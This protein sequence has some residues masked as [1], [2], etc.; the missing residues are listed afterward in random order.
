MNSRFFLKNGE[1]WA[2]EFPELDVPNDTIDSLEH[3]LQ[4]DMGKLIHKII[5]LDPARKIWISTKN[6]YGYGYDRFDR[7]MVSIEFLQKS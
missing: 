7:S 5:K 1:N 4:I 6:G 2:E 3:L